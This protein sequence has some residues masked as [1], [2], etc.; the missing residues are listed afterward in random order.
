[1]IQKK[2]KKYNLNNMAKMEQFNTKRGK[3]HPQDHIP[4][5]DGNM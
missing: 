4:R 2:E 3:Q 5:C 1:M